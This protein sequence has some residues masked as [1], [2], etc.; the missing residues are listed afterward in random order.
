MLGS[1]YIISRTF[2]SVLTECILTLNFCTQCAS[3]VS[4]LYSN[5]LLTILSPALG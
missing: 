5:T 4:P 1:F 3:L 2:K